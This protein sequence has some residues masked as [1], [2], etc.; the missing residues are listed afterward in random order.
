M[1]EI[2]NCK[3]VQDL[4][5]NYIDGLT[6]EET[7]LFI[8]KH[9]KEC[10]KC[11]QIFDNMKKELTTDNNPTR[12][13]RE[14]KYIKKYNKKLKI[15]ELLVVLLLL[16][17]LGFMTNHY[18]TMKNAYNKASNIMV[19]M[20]KEGMYPDTFYAIIE[21]ISDSGVYGIKEIKVKG[22]NIN[23]K[24]HRDEYT[25]SVPL[26]NIG[27]NFKIKWNGKDI[28]FEQLK[29]GQTVA[30][31]NYEDISKVGI[32]EELH[33]IEDKSKGELSQVRMI[34]VLDDTL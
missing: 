32:P 10:S 16:V 28:D 6:N 2:R 5:P 18:F 3:I 8:E 21:E 27:D 31:Y 26:D 4:L 24:N 1:K 33:N 7:N 22:L 25:F 34:V 20:V 23:D 29:V 15:L 9:L 17:A 13:S 14:V 12:N 30:I 11:K 19:D